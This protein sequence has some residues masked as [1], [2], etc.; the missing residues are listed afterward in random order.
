M[1]LRHFDQ[2]LR[3][4][5]A[6]VPNN[7]SPKL[8]P[9]SLAAGELLWALLCLL[10]I[11]VQQPTSSHAQT[12]IEPRNVI[13]LIGDGMGPE[14]VAAGRMYLGRNLSFENLIYQG[15]VTTDNAAG[16][17]TDSAAAGTAIASGHKVNDGVISVA[18]PGDSS[19]LETLLEYFKTRGRQTGLVTTAF[20]TDATPAAFGAHDT[21]RSHTAAIASDFL[22]QTKPNLLLGGGGN[23]M[24]IESAQAAGYSVVTTRAELLALAPAEVSLLSGQFGPGNVPYEYDGL[25]DLPHLSEMTNKALDILE[26][27][28]DGFFLMVEGGLIDKAAHNN[29]INRVV[30]EVVEFENSVAQVLNWAGSRDDT[31]V[32]ITADHETGGLQVLENNGPGQ[33]PTVSWSSGGHTGANVPIYA[34]GYGAEQV[35]G[36]IDNTEIFNIV[37]RAGYVYNTAPQIE[38]G[39]D[40]LVEVNTSANL[41][42]VVLD[43]GISD[44]QDTLDITWSKA[45]GPGQVQFGEAHAAATSVQFFEPGEY[46]LS[47]SADDGL[48]TAID[49]LTITAALRTVCGLGVA[50]PDTDGDLAPDCIDQCPENRDKTEPGICGCEAPDFDADGDGILDCFDQCPT[51]STKSSPGNC[52]CETAETAIDMDSDGL[53]DCIDPDDDNDTV[54]DEQEAADGTDP[55]DRGSFVAQLTATVCSDW[56]GFLGG[57]WNIME[58]VNLSSSPVNVE[59]TL[60]D[61]NG[62]AVSNRSFVILP[63]AQADLTVHDMPGWRLNSYGKVCSRVIGG[64]SGEIDG[65]MVYYRTTPSSSFD[66]AFAMPFTNG[67][68]GPQFVPFN[69][70][71][72]SLD[73]I[74]QLNPVANWIQLTNLSESEQHGE[75]LFHA[76]DGSLL[77]SEEVTLRSGARQD[78]SGHQ[79]GANLVGLIEWRPEDQSAV[80]QLRNVRYVYDNPS[81]NDSFSAAFQLTGVPGSG[82]ELALPLDTAN[83]SAIVELSNTT[84]ASEE[85]TLALYSAEGQLRQFRTMTIP[86]HGTVHVITDSILNSGKGTAIVQGSHREGLLATAMHYGR[87]A[88]GG[89]NYLYAVPAQE[90]L[91]AVLKS[92]YNTFLNQGCRLLL[93]NPGAAVASASVTMTR[94]DG[95]TPLVGQAVDIPANGILDMDLC[96]HDESNKYG[97]VTVRP[98]SANT[99]VGSVIRVGDANQYRFPTPLRQ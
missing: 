14:H 52:G 55:L 38:A 81:G 86:A 53:L 83:G 92:S 36:T 11:A 28:A 67:L 68:S 54:L 88:S 85:V 47:L 82:R 5:S 3:A 69:T 37:V 4:F 40:Q 32:I 60:Y 57:M 9:F 99:L 10:L 26:L 39:E 1:Q 75:L 59:S 41:S 43:D 93:V 95:E 35:A 44:P 58:H 34:S 30:H 16:G 65:R 23:G 12:P 33:M 77:G 98:Q 50:A 91:G 89:L 46:V 80:F 84:N 24:S 51:D 64:Q 87:T 62:S 17:V 97:V 42:G 71:Q 72:P 56:N 63:G 94:Y 70:F 2:N 6:A 27:N 18:L 74:D 7:S 66:F 29:D 25:D 20:M 96:S 21:S 90:T 19:E 78:Y 49:Q 31:L 22:N 8:R 61:I 76:Q 45:S 73:A 79:F 48:L 15:L 13:I